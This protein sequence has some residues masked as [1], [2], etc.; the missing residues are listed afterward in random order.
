VSET[1]VARRYAKGLLAVAVEEKKIEEYG[2]EL[3]TV[4]RLLTDNPELKNAVANPLFDRASRRNLVDMLIGKL[5]L[6]PVMSQFMRLALE[7][8][9]MR[10]VPTISTVYGQLVDDYMNVG[11]ATVTAAVAIPPAAQKQIQAA[12]EKATG[13]TIVLSVE[14]DPGLIGGIKAKVGDLVLDG[15]IRT[16]LESLKNSLKRGEAI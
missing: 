7:K 16:Q 13:K 10:Y 2:T 4:A 6:S 8:E 3:Q 12:L 1:R 15:S 11:R 14:Q 5:S 9:R